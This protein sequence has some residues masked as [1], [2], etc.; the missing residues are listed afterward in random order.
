MLDIMNNKPRFFWVDINLWWLMSS[1]VPWY[2]L[3]EWGNKVAVTGGVRDTITKPFLLQQAQ[4][5][6]A[7]LTLH[8][9]NQ[10][11]L[12]RTAHCSTHSLALSTQPFMCCIDLVFQNV[13]LFLLLHFC[14][15]LNFLKSFT[16]TRVA[17]V[18]P[19]KVG[20]KLID[21]RFMN[22]RLDFP[23][24]CSASFDSHVGTFLWMTLSFK[25]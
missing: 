24:L 20:L 8:L 17:Q 3:Y 19:I 9:K 16:P 12:R 21:H 2:W 15:T 7:N 10:A 18:L 13:S 23:F 22:C 1:N 25:V 11:L 14:S 6:Q 4:N 5:G